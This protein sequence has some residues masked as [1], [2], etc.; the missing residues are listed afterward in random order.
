[1]LQ[2]VVKTY[3][4]YSVRIRVRLA[5]GHLMPYPI[6]PSKGIKTAYFCQTCNY[7]KERGLRPNK[8]SS[9]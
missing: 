5:C 3:R 8:L 6:P 2:Q 4:E 7:N 1:M 9:V